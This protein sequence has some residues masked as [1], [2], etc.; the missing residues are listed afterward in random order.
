M[1]FCVLTAVC[2][3]SGMAGP[4]LEEMRKG[5]RLRDMCLSWRNSCNRKL[6]ACLPC[7]VAAVRRSQLIPVGAVFLS[8]GVHCGA[9]CS[10][11]VIVFRSVVVVDA[12]PQH[13]SPPLPVCAL[14]RMFFVLAAAQW[15]FT[16]EVS[17]LS[18]PTTTTKW[19][20]W[21]SVVIDPV[22]VGSC[23]PYLLSPQ[24]PSGSIA[25]F[26]LSVPQLSVARHEQYTNAE[27]TSSYIFG[28]QHSCR[29]Q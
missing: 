2:S 7:E 13:V 24:N 15:T 4:M 5:R 23:V 21:D 17:T 8:T 3:C 22:A 9:P 12:V 20:R 18:S 19:P 27:E 16:P 11:V 29:G 26:S 10:N 1:F 28:V 14:P 6:L 25:Y